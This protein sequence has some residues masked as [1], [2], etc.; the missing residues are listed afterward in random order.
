MALSLAEDLLYR[1]KIGGEKQSQ[2]PRVC[3]PFKLQSS[4]N[5]GNDK[6]SSKMYKLI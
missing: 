4:N 1:I 6:F 3:N 5:F 2:L